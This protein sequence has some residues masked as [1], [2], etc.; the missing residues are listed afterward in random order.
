MLMD[1]MRAIFLGTVILIRARVFTF[2][3]SYIRGERYFARFHLLLTA[4][5]M[6]MALLIVRP[7]LFRVILG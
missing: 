3:S 2:S 6:S 4:F 5:V 1:E 7:N